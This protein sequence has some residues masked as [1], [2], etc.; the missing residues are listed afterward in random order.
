[1]QTSL[2][3]THR[4]PPRQAADIDIE[5]KMVILPTTWMSHT[6]RQSQ[7]MG[8]ALRIRVFNHKLLFSR[9]TGVRYCCPH[10]TPNQARQLAANWE[11]LIL[12]KKAEATTLCHSV[13]GDSR[14][15]VLHLLGIP[16]YVEAQV[17]NTKGE[18][19][20]DNGELI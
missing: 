4:S 8:V 5:K 3:G 6:C 1:M 10:L 11:I 18:I 13:L 2:P 7:V 19:V 9:E 15:H 20:M 12:M 16:F 14:K 17:Y